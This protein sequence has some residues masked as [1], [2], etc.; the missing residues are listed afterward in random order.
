MCRGDTCCIRVAGLF[1]SV[2]Q[3]VQTALGSLVIVFRYRSDLDAVH[4]E[5]SG[6]FTLTEYLEAMKA[7]L[8]SERFRPGIPSIWDFR[9]VEEASITGEDLRAIAGYQEQIAA[10]RGPT[11]R[12]ALVVASDLSYGLSRMF[13][14][15]AKSA[16]N[17][18]TVF[19]SMEEA[20]AWIGGA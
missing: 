6:D 9:Q 17:E 2:S 7:F 15:Y 3:S 12:V 19:R 16:P 5:I 4:F 14:A 13:E 8:E 1:P 10:N 18:V 11:W 20:E